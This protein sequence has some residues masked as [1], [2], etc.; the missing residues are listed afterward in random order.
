MLTP[1][2]QKAD[3]AVTSIVRVARSLS[4]GRWSQSS[5][6]GEHHYVW[7]IRVTLGVSLFLDSYRLHDEN[8]RLGGLTPWGDRVVRI[9]CILG[10]TGHDSTRGYKAVYLS[11]DG[12][13]FL[14]GSVDEGVVGMYDML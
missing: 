13:S 8:S 3:R 2:N 1:W 9:H 11:V 4:S 14:S 12:V 10:P 5:M 6:A 7:C